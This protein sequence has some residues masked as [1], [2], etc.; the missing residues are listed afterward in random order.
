[1]LSKFLLLV[2][3]TLMFISILPIF[4][5]NIG[6]TEQAIVKACMD[7]G[8]S[9]S[10][11]GMFGR[12]SYD[13]IDFAMDKWY[14]Q[15][16]AELDELDLSKIGMLG[17]I[18][19]GIKTRLSYQMPYLRHWPTAMA[20]GL[21]PYYFG[22]TAYKIHKISDHLWY[23]AGDNSVDYNWYTKRAALSTVYCTTELYMVQDNSRD[24][25]D[26]W[27]F[28][29]NRLNDMSFLGNMANTTHNATLGASKGLLSIFTALIPEPSY[30]QQVDEFER[31]KARYKQ[32]HAAPE[33][34]VAKEAP[35]VPVDSDISTAPEIKTS[36]KPPAQSKITKN[37]PDLSEAV[38]NTM[39]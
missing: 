31:A 20:V 10:A 18:K 35:V 5:R 4:F 30:K 38:K 32:K 22:N 24:F 21:H 28:L 9:P 13:L 34:F 23:V 11:A 14:D 33:P 16:K 27:E 37:T 25:R 7:H 36:P 8:L 39:Q 17:R 15:L 29:D 3:Y 19:T 1:M 12:G 2:E 26:T 6:F